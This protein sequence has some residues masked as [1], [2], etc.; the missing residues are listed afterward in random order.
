[1]LINKGLESLIPAVTINKCC[2]YHFQ[3]G[4]ISRRSALPTIISGVDI[5]SLSF[6]ISGHFD[7][8]TCWILRK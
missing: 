5:D 6:L 4:R 3:P 1:M 8:W 7:K 2:V